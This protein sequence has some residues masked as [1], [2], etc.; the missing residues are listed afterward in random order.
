MREEELKHRPKY[1]HIH[2]REDRKFYNL[3]PCTC[4]HCKLD[5]E[6][7]NPWLEPPENFS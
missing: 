3:P 6:P 5:M 1:P 7:E 4:G 2:D